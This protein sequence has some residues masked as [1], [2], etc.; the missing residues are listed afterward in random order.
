MDRFIG[1]TLGDEEDFNNCLKSN[2]D[3]F[4]EGNAS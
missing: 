1:Y 2:M 4:I 3:R